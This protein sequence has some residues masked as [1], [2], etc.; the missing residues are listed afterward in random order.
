[1][2]CTLAVFSSSLSFAGMDDLNIKSDLRGDYVIGV[3]AHDQREM[4]LKDGYPEAVIGGYIK[5]I[6]RTRAQTFTNSEGPAADELADGLQLFFKK[7]KWLGAAV[8]P[9]TSKDSRAEVENRI[10]KAALKRTVLVTIDD[11]WTESYSNTTVTYKFTITVLNEGAQVLAKVVSEGHH[12]T[13]AWGDDAAGE[14]FSK[15][16]TDTLQKTEFIAALKG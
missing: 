14:I 15:I 7:Q 5:G 8:I 16:M 3:M 4:V 13:R 1:M 11:L 2:L 12:D 10:K 6:F 9:T